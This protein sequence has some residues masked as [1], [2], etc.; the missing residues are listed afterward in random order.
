MK[1]YEAKNIIRDVFESGFDKDKFAY[2]IKNL[3]KNL[4]EKPFGNGGAYTG[5]LIPRAFQSVIRKMERI[6]KF[7]D[8]EGNIIDVLVVELNRDHSIEYA[9]TS[10]RNFIRWYLNGSRGNEFKDAALVAFHTQKSTDWRFSLIKMQYSLEKGKDILTPAKRSSFLVGERGKSHTAQQQLVPLLKNDYPPYLP[11]LE[12]AFNIEAVSDEFYE[13]YKAQLFN[14]K[15]ELDKIVVK[16]SIIKTEFDQK[17]IDTL[18][19]SKKLLGQIVFLYFL[20]KKGWLGLEEGQSYGEGNRNFM[21]ELFNQATA[22]GRNFFNDYLE[23]LFYDALS[24]KHTTDFYEKFNCRI[25]FLNGGLFDPIN[26]YDWEKTDI[27]IPNELFSNKTDEDE[28]GSGI[29]DIFDLYNF[30]VKEDEPLETEVAIDPEMLGKVFERMLEVK[31][32]KSKGAFYTPREI[33]HYMAQ[34]S[35]LYFLDAELKDAVSKED[36]ETFIHFGE[37]IIDKDIAIETGKLKESAN[38]YQIPESIRNNADAIDKALENIKICDP[39]VGSGAFP[40]GVMNEIVKLRNLLTPFV[41]ASGAKQSAQNRTSYFFK[42]NAIQ[43]SIYG[44]DIDP[45]AVEIAKLRL[46]LSMVVD[47]SNINR[48]DPLPNLEYKIVRGNSLINMPDGT[49]RNS[50]LE[51]EIQELTK[52]YYTITDKDE[53]QRQKQIIDEKIKQ[54][55]KSASEWAGYKIDFDFKL[56][57]H[58]VFNEKAST[59][60]GRSDGFDVVIGNPPYI[61][62]YTDKSAFDGTRKQ[63]CYQGKM[64]IWYLFGCKGIDILKPNNGTLTFI[65]TNNWITNAGASKFRNKVLKETTIAEFIDFGDYKIFE[66]AGIQTMVMILQKSVDKE[67]YVCDYAK[68]ID[69]NI[70]KVELVNFLHKIKNDKYTFFQAVINRNELIG[71]TIHF[72]Q[73]NI[74]EILDKIKLKQNFSLLENEVGNGIHPHH[75][76]VNKKMLKKL[77]NEFSIGDGIFALSDNELYSLN[78]NKKEKELIKPYYSTK[79]FQKY[80]ANAKNNEWLIYTTSKFKNPN[81][82]LPYPNIKKHLDKFQDVI[83]S[84]NKPYG[85]HRARDEKFFN[86]EKIIVQR[87]CPKEPIFSYTNFDCYISATFYVIKTNRINQKYMVALLNSKL[88]AFWL[89]FKGKMQGDNFQ[90]DKEPLLS[91]PILKI[92]NTKPFETLVDYILFLKSQPDDKQSFYFEQIIDGMVYELYFEEEIKKAGCEII[93]HLQDLPE[94]T[95]S[96]SDSEKQRITDKVFAELYDKNRPVRKNLERMEKEVEEVKIIKESLG[97]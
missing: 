5:N 6:G 33:V 20:Q 76:Y 51:D 23:F 53:K 14:L 9:R 95:E 10:Q 93:K 69:K 86:G 77:S 67:L 48:I 12:E 82:I 46:W 45:G 28:E 58:E 74:A 75:D 44:V 85:L 26:F 52:H 11:D 47:E 34:Q 87:K 81:Y 49:A 83:T 71:K 92:K 31:E 15:E 16:D 22:K 32:R 29:L 30:T 1:L 94:L 7:E 54:L 91:I 60:Q 4:Q 25:P 96:M 37:Q 21:R 35:L 19:F 57:F 65:A 3:L 64:D 36:L 2:F 13:K 55:L 62:E 79:N 84:D 41:I 24:Q 50:N 66:S 70:T 68:I 89:K 18:N 80:Y 78:L 17:N 43:N 56:Y 73:K 40:V 38:K 97:K 27:I 59:E 72:L 90:I 88:I 63:E 61:K 39:A 8:E 42:A